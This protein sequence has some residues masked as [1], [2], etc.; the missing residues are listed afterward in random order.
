MSIHQETKVTT[1]EQDAL[2]TRTLE[3][4]LNLG[5]EAD[6][7]DEMTIQSDSSG[8]RLVAMAR[9]AAAEALYCLEHVDGHWEVLMLT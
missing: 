3:T 4:C 1:E 5:R 9:G 8:R 2:I 6:V 7:F